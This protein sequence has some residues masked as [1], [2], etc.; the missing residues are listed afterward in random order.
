MSLFFPSP[1]ST[2]IKVL[3]CF[4]CLSRASITIALRSSHHKLGYRV[5][6][7]FLNY[8]L[9]PCLN[10]KP[11]IFFEIL[12]TIANSRQ[13]RML[14]Q[15]PITQFPDLYLLNRWRSAALDSVFRRW[16]ARPWRRSQAAFTSSCFNLIKDSSGWFSFNRKQMLELCKGEIFPL[17]RHLS[18]HTGSYFVRGEE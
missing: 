7:I 16:R 10:G 14:L 11:V 4:S 17:F 18:F 1:L 6:Y 5:A 3:I 2:L 15:F 13:K 8:S 9:P 12:A